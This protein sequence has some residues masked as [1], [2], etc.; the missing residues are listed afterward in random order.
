MSITHTH[1]EG[2]DAPMRV[3]TQ[4]LNAFRVNACARTDVGRV[5][6]RNEDQYLI[7]DVTS[8]IQV[9]DATL[10]R[11]DHLYLGAAPL[12]LFIVADGMGG[13]AGGERAS[14]L[15]VSAVESFLLRALGHIG[16][17]GSLG[18]TELLR[19]SF[20]EADGTVM[21][22][23]QSNASLA[24]MG[25]T[26][27]VAMVSGSEVH[28]AHAGDSRAYL[29]RDRKLKRLTRDHT[30]AE[31]LRERGVSDAEANEPHLSNIITNAV[32]GGTPGVNPD[33]S[34][35]D[36]KAGDQLLL[37][38]DGLTKMVAD[39]EIARILAECG[40]P[41]TACAKL[42]DTALAN[43]GEDNVTVLVASF[44]PV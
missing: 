21:A 43:G 22:A 18:A 13:H 40:G 12:S 23:A 6:E 2:R 9:K 30:V 28:V 17:L 38:S 7:G 16:T 36:L 44:E 35:M 20:Q 19:A 37:C 14:A 29:L 10:C 41:Q 26:M 39:D 24:G 27:T 34:R 3:A 25:T 5:R 32:G 31:A 15:A 8:A 4:T 42:V 1:A 11:P 33:I